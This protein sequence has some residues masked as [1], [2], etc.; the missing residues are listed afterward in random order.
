MEAREPSSHLARQDGEVERV[1]GQDTE[2]PSGPTDESIAHHLAVALLIAVPLFVALWVGVI[3]LAA[4]IA[5][6]SFEAPL[7][8]AAGIG[9][10]AGVFWAAWYAFVSYARAEEAER[11]PRPKSGTSAS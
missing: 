11:R 2:R 7:A 8:M 3:A 4:D 1:D 6:F 9:V 10:L 5:H